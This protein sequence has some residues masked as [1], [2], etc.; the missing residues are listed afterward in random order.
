MSSGLMHL[1]L[2]PEIREEGGRENRCEAG[3]WLGRWPL[4]ELAGAAEPGWTAES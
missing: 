1:T 2:K 4:E 3:W